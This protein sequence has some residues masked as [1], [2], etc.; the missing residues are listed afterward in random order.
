MNL[1]IPVKLLI[2]VLAFL[3]LSLCACGALTRSDEPAITTWWL[4]PYT[5]GADSATNVDGQPQPVMVRVSAIPGLDND[6][7][8]ALTADSELKPYAG[9]RWADH[10]PELAG[11][12]I[13]RSLQA[14]GRFELVSMGNHGPSKRCNL[15]LEVRQF[16]ARISASGQTDRVTVEMN[17]FYQCGADVIIPIQV[18]SSLNVQDSRMNSIVAAFQQAFDNVLKE[19]LREI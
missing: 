18:E 14:S 7:I 16:F 17:G 12:L 8:L 19:L 6:R 5:V 3:V 15:T 10:L 2:L 13:G 9:A 11:S 4:A 1:R